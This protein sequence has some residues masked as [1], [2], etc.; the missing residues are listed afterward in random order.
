MLGLPVALEPNLEVPFPFPSPF[1]LR[2]GLALKVGGEDF[3][4]EEEL[5]DAGLDMLEPENE[6]AKKVKAT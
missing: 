4:P 1:P 3:F 5:A 6:E 2:K